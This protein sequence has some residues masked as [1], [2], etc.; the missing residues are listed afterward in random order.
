MNRYR[1]IVENNS[2][3]FSSIGVGQSFTA[4]GVVYLRIAPVTAG[5]VYGCNAVRI[6]AQAF[7]GQPRFRAFTSYSTVYNANMYHL[8]HESRLPAG[9]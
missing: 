4:D 9:F 5:G 7:S 1:K 6:S 3:A 2:V 8:V